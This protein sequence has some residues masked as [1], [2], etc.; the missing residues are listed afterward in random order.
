[1]AQIKYAD[2][3]DSQWKSRRLMENHAEY[4]KY[5]ESDKKIHIRTDPNWPIIERSEDGVELQS[6]SQ[7]DE[8]V[9]KVW[10]AIKAMCKGQGY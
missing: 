8:Q 2:E 7:T 9:D 10:E 4:M 5:L 1:M 3:D 6:I